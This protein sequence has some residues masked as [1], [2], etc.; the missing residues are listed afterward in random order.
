MQAM[1][2]R[3]SWRRYCHVTAI[4]KTQMR[5]HTLPDTH[6]EI[7]EAVLEARRKMNCADTIFIDIPYK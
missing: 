1:S 2:N 6:T 5:K 7:Q 3:P 4:S